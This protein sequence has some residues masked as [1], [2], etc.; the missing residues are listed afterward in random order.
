ML[1]LQFLDQPIRHHFRRLRALLV[2]NGTG[3]SLRWLSLRIGL[4]VGIS[5]TPARFVVIL[6]THG[7][8]T[9]WLAFLLLK[10]ALLFS[11]NTRRSA[12]VNLHASSRLLKGFPFPTGCR[13]L[14]VVF[15]QP[16]DSHIVVYPISFRVLCNTWLKTVVL[17][18]KSVS[19]QN[20][21]RAGMSAC[22]SK[23]DNSVY[24]AYR[25][26][27][28]TGSHFCISLNILMKN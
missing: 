26:G 4:C 23:Y 27:A 28:K 12:E 17:T 10:P 14:L 8:L 20:A 24:G 1:L 18:A 13:L 16:P 21:G 22:Q 9:L 15:F 2:R 19:G 6:Y 25:T 3:T 5:Y 7:R 11:K